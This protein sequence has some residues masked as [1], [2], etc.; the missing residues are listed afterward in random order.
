MLGPECCFIR[1]VEVLPQHVSN[2]PHKVVTL[3]LK[4]PGIHCAVK[5]DVAWFVCLNA[6]QEVGYDTFFYKEYCVNLK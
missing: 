4:S 6:V 2:K 5:P 1:K 3:N